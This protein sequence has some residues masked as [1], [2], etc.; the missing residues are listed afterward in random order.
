M[1]RFVF[2]LFGAGRAGLIHLKNILKNPRIDLKYIVEDNLSLAEGLKSKYSLDGVV[3]IAAQDSK[4]I[5]ED[6]KV[7][8]IIVCT[9]TYTHEEIVKNA[10]LNN[11][12]VFCEKPIA[13]DIA[14]TLACYE[15]AEKTGKPL[16]CSFNRRFDPN[17]K[18][19]REKVISGALGNVHIV[20][21]TARDHPEPPRS[22]LE[23]SGGIYHDC[24]IHDI[25]LVCWILNEYPSQVYAQGVART[26][27]YTEMDDVD[28]VIMTLTFPSGIIATIDLSRL[29]CYGY[30]QRIE[31]FGSKGMLISENQ[32]PTSVTHY[33]SS[34]C[35]DDILKWSF[36]QRYAESYVNVL[37]HFLDV[38]EGSQKIS[39]TKFQTLNACELSSACEKSARS[40]TIV[41]I[42]MNDDGLISFN[43]A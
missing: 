35:H 3:I 36:P 26:G 5:Y 29:A 4:V 15:T 18:G 32:K 22:Y 13:G 37:E 16:L 39:I 31:V 23:I 17:I 34:G 10:L 21:T 43:D 27:Q 38:L 19:V 25:D 42:S 1:K 2:A 9:P 28:T 8:A 30:D 7:D 20:K 40:N 12:G 14:G 11:K 6:E 33:D 24:G 41:K